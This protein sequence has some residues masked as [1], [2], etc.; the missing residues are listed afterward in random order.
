MDGSENQGS[1]GV[2]G[3]GIHQTFDH[4]GL[5]S[6]GLMF[7]L[8]PIFSVCQEKIWWAAW[9]SNPDKIVYETTTLTA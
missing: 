4:G 5:F 8:Y 1:N 7:R 2:A 9:D 3:R 6:F